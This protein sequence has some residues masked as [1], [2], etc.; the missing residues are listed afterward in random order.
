MFF[1]IS[2]QSND[3][4]SC[5]F[6]LPNGLILNTDQGWKEYHIDSFHVVYKGYHSELFAQDLLFQR[7]LENTTPR[8]QGSFYMIISNTEQTVITHNIDRSSPLV[9]RA[10][11]VSNLY[12]VSN[13]NES[14]IW[15]DKYITVTKNFN[16]EE[17]FYKPYDENF[18]E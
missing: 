5:T 8:Y 14:N 7:M 10:N 2:K 3:A 13:S 17:N 12:T 1:E 16:I 11:S 6:R 9:L 15:A 4:F 18:S